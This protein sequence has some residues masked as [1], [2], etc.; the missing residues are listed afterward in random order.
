MNG[1]SG[2][3]FIFAIHILIAVVGKLICVWNGFL[4]ISN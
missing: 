1:I 3:G 4:Y 2:A